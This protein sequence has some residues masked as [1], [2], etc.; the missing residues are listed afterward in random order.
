M[1]SDADRA[2]AARRF[3][4]AR[5]RALDESDIDDVLAEFGGDHR[6]AIGALLKDLEAF[7]KDSERIVSAGYVWGRFLRSRYSPRG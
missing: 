1:A 6:A 2:G 3:V 7:A 5:E 4:E